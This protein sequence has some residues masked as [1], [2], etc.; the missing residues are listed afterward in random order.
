MDELLG[1]MNAIY[2]ILDELATDGDPT[3]PHT[4]E[5]ARRRDETRDAIDQLVN[6]GLGETTDHL[7]TAD[8]E[9]TDLLADIQKQTSRDDKIVHALSAG[10]RVIQ[11]AA[12]IAAAIL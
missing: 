5:V 10:S 11:L 12:Q 8:G 7:A 6:R 9:L 2:A 3:D 1:R 4:I